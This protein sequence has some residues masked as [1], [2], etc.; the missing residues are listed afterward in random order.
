MAATLAT[1]P[2][3]AADTVDQSSDFAGEFVEDPDYDDGKTRPNNEDTFQY[4][5]GFSF[6]SEI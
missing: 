2:A 4:P 6:P 3:K 5:H 1:A